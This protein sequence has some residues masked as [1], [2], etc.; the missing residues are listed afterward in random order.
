[1]LP[2]ALVVV[3]SV[4]LFLTGRPAEDSQA[5]AQPS[6]V[7]GEVKHEVVD[8][9]PPRTLAEFLDGKDLRHTTDAELLELLDCFPPCAPGPF[10]SDLV[11]YLYAQRYEDVVLLAPFVIDPDRA[12]KEDYQMALSA[13]GKV[14]LL[15][16][17]LIDGVLPEGN[18]LAKIS[19]L[20]FEVIGPN[21][22]IWRF[23]IHNEAE[24]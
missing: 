23:S 21:G 10:S 22:K 2:T 15:D 3:V 20:F 24:L 16:P 18:Y 13:R 11:A 17:P 9:L 6:T 14:Y 1:M 8:S 12:W 19:G 7:S 4:L 5:A